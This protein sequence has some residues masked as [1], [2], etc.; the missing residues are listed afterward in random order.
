LTASKT[1]DKALKY[2]KKSVFYEVK[3]KSCCFLISR[4][5]KNFQFSLVLY[6]NFKYKKV[7]MRKFHFQL[8][9]PT[10]IAVYF[11]LKAKNCFHIDN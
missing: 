5:N 11:P 8:T 10:A 7:I 9:A 6:Q 4:T 2:N 3:K 1:T